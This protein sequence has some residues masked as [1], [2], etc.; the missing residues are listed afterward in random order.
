MPQKSFLLFC[1]CS[2]TQNG[3]W[4]GK[5]NDG[6]NNLKAPNLITYTCP[7]TYCQCLTNND[8]KTCV[9]EYDYDDPDKQCHPPRYGTKI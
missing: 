3:Y 8:T 5:V 1:F 4:A 6:A 9:T 7:I 2:P